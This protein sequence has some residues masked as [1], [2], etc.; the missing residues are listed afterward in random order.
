[1]E[2]LLVQD[3]H[4]GDDA[5]YHE[6]S[7][8]DLLYSHEVWE[9]YAVYVGDKA[10]GI[11]LGMGLPNY[12]QLS[13][14]L[15]TF[16]TGKKEDAAE[17]IGYRDTVMKAYYKHAVKTGDI[18]GYKF[19]TDVYPYVNKPYKLK[20]GTIVYM[21]FH[22]YY[23]NSV[24]PTVYIKKDFKDFKKSYAK[25]GYDAPYSDYISSE[26]REFDEKGREVRTNAPEFSWGIYAK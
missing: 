23:T 16:T 19:N 14:D 1:M 24:G 22:G 12:T 6:R 9:S 8:F 15:I 21:D 7:M 25:D 4:D 2:I 11:T 26:W 20:S 3:H 17:I 13:K 10:V 5:Y 18:D